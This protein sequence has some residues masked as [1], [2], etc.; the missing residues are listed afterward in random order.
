M[1][2]LQVGKYYFPYRGG[3][4]SVVQSLSEGLTQ[5]GNEIGVLC[6]AEKR[7]F[8]T[9]HI[10]GVNIH[11]AAQLGV[12]FSQPIT[13]SW[14]WLYQKLVKEHD[15]IHI[16]GPNP[17]AEL[18]VLLFPKTKPIVVSYH[19][20]IVN[21]KW[22][23]PFYRPLQRA[24]LKKVDKIIVATKNHIRFSEVLQEFQDKIEVIPYGIDPEN[25]SMNENIEMQVERLKEQHGNFSL[26]VGR[27]VGYKGLDIL[28]RSMQE[29]K[30][31]LLIVGEGPNRD[32]LVDLA[33]RLGVDDR[34]KFIG[35]VENQDT[36]TALFHACQVLVLP[37]ISAAENF[38]IVQIEAMCC[39]KPIITSNLKSGVPVV[40]QMGATS[41]LTPPGDHE[42]LADALNH[43]L[44]NPKLVEIMGRKGQARFHEMFTLEKMI[45]SHLNLYTS[46]LEKAPSKNLAA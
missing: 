40:G 16:H 44:K 29:V 6:S 42:A 10:R 34:V 26:F 28:I 17:L 12:L 27:L 3:I 30:H 32:Q 25:F 2:I 9:E 36:F 1:K 45:N 39:G 18:S 31:P 7:I 20:D 41:I 46:L 19:A 38:G 24:F 22:L 33:Y 13:P 43:L 23:R 5:A 21:Q 35:K 8:T 11:R 14:P 4:E 15:V 37:S